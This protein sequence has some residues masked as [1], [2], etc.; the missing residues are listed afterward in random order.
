MKFDINWGFETQSP[1]S[2]EFVF[3]CRRIG[4]EM[5]IL[6]YVSVLRTLKNFFLLLLYDLLYK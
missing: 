1:T 4:D 6:I 5:G 2:G 3:E